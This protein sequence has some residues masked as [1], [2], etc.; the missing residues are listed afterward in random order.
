MV[1]ATALPGTGTWA[2]GAG[3]GAAIGST[4]AA[5]DQFSSGG[6]SFGQVAVAGVLGAVSGAA[7]GAL[8]QFGGGPLSGTIAFATNGIALGALGACFSGGCGR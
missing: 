3:I 6:G 2:W 4:V 7:S 1:V 5:I 8:V